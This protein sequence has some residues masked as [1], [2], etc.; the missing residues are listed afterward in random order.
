[1]TKPDDVL[2]TPKTTRRTLH[3]IALFE[4]LKGLA[5][6]AVL[7]GVIDLMHRDV[8]RIAV[9]LIGRFGLDPDGRYPSL[10]LHY[11]ELLPDANVNVMLLL[12]LAYVALRW[13]EAFGLWRDRSWGEWLA[14][15]SGGLYIPFEA[16][17]LLHRPTAINTAVLSINVFMVAFLSYQLWRRKAGSRTF[18][19]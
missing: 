15:V 4:F 5:A 2:I 3:A 10:F 9:A 18:R 6:L 12:G 16:V 14:A 7:I 17:H 1:M 8:R 19:A 11:A 13:M